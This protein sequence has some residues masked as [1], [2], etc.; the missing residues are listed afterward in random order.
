MMPVDSI[1]STIESFLRD[2]T[3]WAPSEWY[4]MIS[5]ARTNPAKYEC[6]I[7]NHW[8]FKD[9]KSY[10]QALFPNSKLISFPTLRSASF[11]KNNP[12]IKLKYGFFDN[13]ETQDYDLDST[14]RSRRNAAIIASEPL[15][16]YKNKLKLSSKKFKDLKRLCENNTIPQNFRNE[17]LAL[18]YDE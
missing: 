18:Q 14:A 15:P 9:R 11:E 13:S 4:T 16:L 1:H 6:I 3:V 5:G 2:R 10:S 17:Y 12:N 8:D 7:M